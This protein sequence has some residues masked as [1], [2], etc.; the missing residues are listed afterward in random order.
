M[1][2]ALRALCAG[3]ETLGLRAGL[4]VAKIERGKL[5]EIR[6]TAEQPGEARLSPTC[7]P[8]PHMQELHVHQRS[9]W[10]EY[11]IELRDWRHE[12]HLTSPQTSI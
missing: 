11:F 9:D 5:F 2:Q 6:L 8:W 7:S 1:S 4:D 3:V 12:V 10:M